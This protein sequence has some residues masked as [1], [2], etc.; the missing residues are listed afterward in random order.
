[1]LLE[2]SINNYNYRVL[3]SLLLFIRSWKGDLFFSF[4][5]H[6]CNVM[7]ILSVDL[8][9]YKQEGII[10]IT[11]T[12]ISIVIAAWYYTTPCTHCC[13]SCLPVCPILLLQ[14]GCVSM[15]Y[16][17]HVMDGA[18]L[19]RDNRFKWLVPALYKHWTST[20]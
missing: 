12:H 10:I 13:V 17:I 8:W 3:L 14:S 9:L 5:L 2:L 20:S 4:E 11:H 16:N 1:M 18:V 15:H 19:K 6:E 7:S